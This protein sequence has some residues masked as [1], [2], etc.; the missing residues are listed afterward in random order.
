M[1]RSICAILVCLF[2]LSCWSD[3]EKLPPPLPQ[4]GTALPYAQITSR[5]AAQINSAKD[6]HFLNQWDGVVDSSLQLEQSAGYLMRSP[7]LADANKPRVQKE[8]TALVSNIKEMREAARVKDE[9]KSLE[10]IRRIHN[11]I[12]ELQ[13]LR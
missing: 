12:R 7:D 3:A 6:A 2:C 5:L 4:D 13:D 8:T 9:V 10:L 1:R 11:Q